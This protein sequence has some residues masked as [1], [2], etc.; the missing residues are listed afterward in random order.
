MRRR[1]GTW[2]HRSRRVL[3]MVTVVTVVAG[4]LLLLIARADVVQGTRI[5]YWQQQAQPYGT[6][7]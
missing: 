4:L 6:V 3:T 1:F 7:S 2:R 5:S